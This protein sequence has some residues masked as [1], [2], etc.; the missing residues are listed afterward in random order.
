MNDGNNPPKQ[1]G[2]FFYGCLTLAALGLLMIIGLVVGAYFLKKTVN[3][4][5]D[6]YTDNAPATM[7]KVDYTSEQMDALRT[8]LGAFTNAMEKGGA[9]AELVL[10]A[11]DLNAFITA[12]KDLN[13]KAFIQFDD[14]KVKGS[15]SLPLPDMGPLKLK[16]RYL[17]GNA[18]F[19]VILENGILDVTL[20][21]VE[22]KGKALPDVLMKE[23]KKENLAKE[24]VKDPDATATIEKLETIQIKG[25]KLVLRSSGKTSPTQERAPPPQ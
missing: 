25:G 18:T 17:N 2:C 16:G 5:I 22:V 4:W 13:G 3:R 14:D 1:R 7:Q 8:R 23:L 10:S 6:E 15:I 9:P 19:K 24:M 12:S 20:D 21:A 11:D